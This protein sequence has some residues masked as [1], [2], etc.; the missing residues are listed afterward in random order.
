VTPEVGADVPSPPAAPPETLP[1]PPPAHADGGTVS[2]PDTHDAVKAA[3]EATRRA[4]EY[5]RQARH[6]QTIAQYVD[7]MPGLSDHKRDFLKR[8]PLLLQ[9]D[10]AQ[11][12]R[13]HY[14]DA[15]RSGIADDSQQMD[16]HLVNAMRFEFEARRQRQIDSAHDAVIATPQMPSRS[17][18]QEAERLD[19]QAAAIR[20]VM[21][22]EDAVS[23][24]VAPVVPPRKRSIPYSA[25]VSRDVPT[26]DGRRMSEQRTVTLSAEERALAHSSYGWMSKA[27]AEREYGRQ[28]LRLAEM[29]RRGEYP[30]R[31]RN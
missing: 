9:Q 23:T 26:A 6:T 8:Y 19:Q 22:A 5:Q 25:P 24:E 10:N 4:E 2:A 16:D 28:K 30:E 13:R 20:N 17:S 14:Q 31:E 18:E 7:A 3:L 11:A 1:T 29:R 27:E 12:M 15:L 21:S